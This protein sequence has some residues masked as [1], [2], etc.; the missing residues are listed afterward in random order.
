MA[1]AIVG[2]ISGAPTLLLTATPLQNSLLELYGLVSVID[3]H[4]FGDLISFRE[5]FLRTNNEAERNRLLKERLAPLCRR[6]L[7]KQVLEYIRFT[8]RVPIT[9]DFLPTDAEHQLYE[10]V[11]AY[12]QRDELHALPASQRTLMTLILRKLLASSTFAI[13]GTLRRLVCRLEHPEDEQ[14][15]TLPITEEE[16]EGVEELQDEWADGNGELQTPAVATT[17]STPRSRNSS[18]TR[19]SPNPSSTTRRATRSSRRL[20]PP[21]HARP[22]WERRGRR[23]SSPSP[24]AR[25]RTSQASSRSTGTTSRSSS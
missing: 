16:L 20:R 25:R 2:A 13:A 23:W 14:Q 9:Q 3:P 21:S 17:S 18:A 1:A 19:I 22:S 7:R 15:Q 6:T 24:G 4:V 8:Q 10:E 5:Q 11:S 12:L